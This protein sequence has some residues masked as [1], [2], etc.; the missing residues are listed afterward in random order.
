MGNRFEFRVWH[1]G[2]K[3]MYK[4]VAIG[5]GKNKIGYKLSGKKRYVW[6][7][8][9]NV[10]V[11]QAIGIKDKKEKRIFDGDILELSNKERD[12]ISIHWEKTKYV[13]KKKGSKK[14]FDD[15]KVWNRLKKSKIIG[16]IYETPEL[17]KQSLNPN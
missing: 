13:L 9:D 2:K 17:L 15:P 1:K 5:A 8:Y 12:I 11:N 10:V 3:Y 16:N 6:E 4:N 7:E 14:K